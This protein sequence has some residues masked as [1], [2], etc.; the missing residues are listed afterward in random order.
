[1]SHKIIEFQDGAS[2][3]LEYI[4]DDET[5]LGRLM[6]KSQMRVLPRLKNREG[7]NNYAVL[8]RTHAQSRAVEEVMIE[9]SIPYQIVGGLKFYERKEI[10]DVLSYLRLLINPNDLISLKRIINVPP[11]G[12]GPKTFDLVKDAMLEKN[13]KLFA[14]LAASKSG[15]KNFF[16]V[17]D[18]IAKIPE[19]T[20]ILDVLRQTVRLTGYEKFLRDGTEEG[21]S[22]FENIQELFNV[23][24][25][26]RKEP[27]KEGL[28][29]FLEE[30]ALMT[31]ADEVDLDS[32]KVTLMT[33]H[34]AKGLEFETVFLIGLEEGLLPH[35]RSLLEPKETAEEIRLAYVG[36]TRARKRLFLVH[37]LSRK[38]YGL[39]NVS[40]P[41]RILKAI[42]EE[43]LQIYEPTY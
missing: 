3:E 32:P 40:I 24:G 28:T 20:S 22:R 41:S 16:E 2:K 27:W 36:V 15:I 6:R 30:V 5:I 14:E 23:A 43:L 10:K 12:I 21:E 42:P 4:P 9:S 8:Y 17:M 33:L 1:V 7:L 35:A 26:Y 34:Q 37:A 19:E 39:R 13:D 25:I 11:R 29:K 18:A 38:Q 31:S